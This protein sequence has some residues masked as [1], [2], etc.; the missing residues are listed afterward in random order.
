MVI[1]DRWSQGQL[2][3]WNLIMVVTKSGNYSQISVIRV[4]L[5]AVKTGC[6]HKSAALFCNDDV[7]Q[8]N[9]KVYDNCSNKEYA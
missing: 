3:A 9:D 5:G 2:N 8:I 6:V 1:I 4:I 7:C